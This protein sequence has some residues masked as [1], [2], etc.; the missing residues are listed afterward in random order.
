MQTW[1]TIGERGSEI[2]TCDGMPDWEW[3]KCHKSNCENF[4]CERLSATFCYL[5]ADGLPTLGEVIDALPARET[6]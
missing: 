4:V 5:H 1:G 6:V 3:A 2:F